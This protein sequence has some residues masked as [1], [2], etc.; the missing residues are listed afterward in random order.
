MNEPQ[1]L[2]SWLHVGYDLVLPVLLICSVADSRVSRGIA[3]L[4]ATFAEARDYFT[5]ARG[6]NALRLA[7][8]GAELRQ[9]WEA[10]K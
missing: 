7:E 2:A 1:T 3:V 10:R 8:H 6:L 4:F 5:L 9:E